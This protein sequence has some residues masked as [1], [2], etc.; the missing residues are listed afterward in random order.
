MAM[1]SRKQTE[2]ADETN[3]RQERIEKLLRELEY[4]VTR[5]MLEKEIGEEMGFRFYV[6]ISNKLPEGVVFCEF[7]TRPVHRAYMHPDDMTPR[8]KVVRS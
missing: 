2:V 7:R 1:L 5:G 6:P 4:E 3:I 8:L